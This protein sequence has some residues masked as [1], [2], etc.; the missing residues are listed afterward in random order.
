MARSVASQLEST[1][2]E[3]QLATAIQQMAIA[4]TPRQKQQRQFHLAKTEEEWRKF[5][6]KDEKETAS[7]STAIKHDENVLT[8]DE[9]VF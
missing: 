2:E 1:A 5:L 4:P 8:E 7:I 6:T 9:K 3:C